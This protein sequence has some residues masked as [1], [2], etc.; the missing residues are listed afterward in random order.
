MEKVTPQIS[1][2]D[3]KG[4]EHGKAPISNGIFVGAR[5]CV[6]TVGIAISSTLMQKVSK[7]GKM[8]ER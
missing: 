4:M 8:L 7:Q 6:G 1:K 3:V 5:K 2:G